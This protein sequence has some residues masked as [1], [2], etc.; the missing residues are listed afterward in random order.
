MRKISIAIIAL[1]LIQTG[2]AGLAFLTHHSR[3]NCINNESVSWHKGHKYWL[4]VTS[5]HFWPMSGQVI[6]TACN[7]KKCHWENTWRAAAVCWTEGK[8]GWVV[9]GKHFFTLGSDAI[10]KMVAQETV[11]DC[12]IYDG[13][14][15]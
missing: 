8:G 12:S 1:L 15:D 13:W 9:S 14:W 3:A 10:G 5:E 6:H 2:H 11:V 7:E 4:L